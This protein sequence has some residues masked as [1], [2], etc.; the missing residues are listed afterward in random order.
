MITP[1]YLPQILSVHVGIDLCRRD[2]SMSQHLLDRA[3][4]G[5]AF[6]QVRG[7]GM[8]QRVWINTFADPGPLHVLPQDLPRPHTRERPAAGIEEEDSL[9]RPSFQCRPLLAH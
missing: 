3:Q 1:V 5:A 6:Q 7:E 4:I 9:P 2:V 8:P